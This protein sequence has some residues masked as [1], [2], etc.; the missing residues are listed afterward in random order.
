MRLTIPHSSAMFVSSTLSTFLWVSKG[1]SSMPPW[2]RAVFGA[3]PQFIF[4]GVVFAI[5]SDLLKIILVLGIRVL[6]S[7]EY[8]KTLYILYIV[9]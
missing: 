8:L 1:G 3:M 5:F 6:V 7:M 2:L 9:Y 4:F